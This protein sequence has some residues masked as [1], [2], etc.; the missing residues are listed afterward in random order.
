[1]RLRTRINFIVGI[2][3][4]SICCMAGLGL[5][6]AHVENVLISYTRMEREWISRDGIAYSN[7]GIYFK[8]GNVENI[9]M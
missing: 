5:V 2:A 3:L 7:L 8:T 1:M 9:D 6:I 4:A